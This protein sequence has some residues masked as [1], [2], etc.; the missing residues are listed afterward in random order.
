[1]NP[2]HVAV[3][4]S[5]ARSFLAASL[6]LLLAKQAGGL[7]VQFDEILWAG[8]AAVAPVILRALDSSDSGFGKNKAA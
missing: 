3:L 6:A 5:Y 2:Q 1:M 4:K 7:D 8:I